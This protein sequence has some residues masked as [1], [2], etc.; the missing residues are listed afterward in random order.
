MCGGVSKRS[1]QD[2]VGMRLKQGEP[3]GRNIVG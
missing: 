1:D 2:A 3:G